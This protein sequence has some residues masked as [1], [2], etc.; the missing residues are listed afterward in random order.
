MRNSAGKELLV[1]SAPFSLPLSPLP[2][3]RSCNVKHLQRRH[4]CISRLERPQNWGENCC[5]VRYVILILA[6][7]KMVSG[8]PAG[9][10]PWPW[11][12][13]LAQSGGLASLAML[14][15]S[16]GLSVSGLSIISYDAKPAD[17]SIISYDAIV[18]GLSVMMLWSFLGHAPSSTSCDLLRSFSSCSSG[19]RPLNPPTGINLGAGL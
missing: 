11:P 3:R 2:L 14:L 12:R 16:P 9:R 15:S 17:D 13:P 7:L 8:Q 18:T 6:P 5:E 19:G 4:V 10:A 1:D